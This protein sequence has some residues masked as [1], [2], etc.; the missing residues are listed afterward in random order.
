MATA[1][2]IAATVGEFRAEFTRRIDEYRA[3]NIITAS[4]A[5]GLEGLVEWA[6]SIQTALEECNGVP[7]PSHLEMA[8]AAE[9]DDARTRIKLTLAQADAVGT[10]IA[11]M[12][13]HW[14]D[15]ATAAARGAAART[16]FSM[17]LVGA[18]GTRKTS[19][20]LHL[21]PDADVNDDLLRRLAAAKTV[22]ASHAV[23]RI[24]HVLRY[25]KG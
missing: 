19:R 9:S 18:H 2:D 21:S 1:K 17:P 24:R 5:A 20:L 25:H 7:S 16:R 15:P 13:T 3:E 8:V 11:D 22:S 4:A 6:G 23:A 14:C 10:V 12:A